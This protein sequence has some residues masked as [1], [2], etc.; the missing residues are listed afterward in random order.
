LAILTLLMT[1]A[2]FALVE[3]LVG[4]PYRPSFYMSPLLGAGDVQTVRVIETVCVLV[5]IGAA[6]YLRTSWSHQRSAAA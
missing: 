1:A 3:S 2:V 5:A 4:A 6:A